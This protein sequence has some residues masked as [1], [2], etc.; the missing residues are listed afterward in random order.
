[1]VAGTRSLR[2]PASSIPGGSRRGR[3]DAGTRY[4]QAGETT[5]FLSTAQYKTVQDK[6]VNDITTEK[7]RASNQMDK[8]LEVI[9]RKQTIRNDAASRLMP[10]KIEG[11]I[12]CQ[13]IGW[14]SLWRQMRPRYFLILQTTSFIFRFV[15]VQIL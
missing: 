13:K 15:H 4:L 3:T 5:M 2:G 10:K 11:M 7:N 14:E 12:I 6:A 9:N 1:M 8:M